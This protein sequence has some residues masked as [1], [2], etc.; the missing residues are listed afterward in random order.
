MRQELLDA[1]RQNGFIANYSGVRISSKGKRFRLQDAT[2]WDVRDE[3]GVLCG[4]ACT[5]ARSKVE[6]L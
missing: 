2:V 5:F 4:Q 3:Q 1:V 6:F